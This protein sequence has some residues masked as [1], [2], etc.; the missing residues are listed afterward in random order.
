MPAFAVVGKRTHEGN[1]LHHMMIEGCVISLTDKTSQVALVYSQMNEPPGVRARVA[2][3]G[4]TVVEYFCDQE[5][6]DM[7]LFIDNIFRFTQVG[8][9]SGNRN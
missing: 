3:T 4:L 7:L 9:F 8:F 6:Q 5:G 2:L 1:N